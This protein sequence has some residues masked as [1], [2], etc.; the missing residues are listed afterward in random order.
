M[1]VVL[2]LTP[3]QVALTPVPATVKTLLLVPLVSPLTA[4]SKVRVR[5]MVSPALLPAV[6]ETMLR[7]VLGAGLPKVAMVSKVKLNVVGALL[8]PA[9]SCWRTCTV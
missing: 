5:V 7:A 1:R 4:P 2:P 3:P 9:T 6:P 8:L